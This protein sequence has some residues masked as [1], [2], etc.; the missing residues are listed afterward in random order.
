MMKKSSF[1]TLKVLKF[2]DYSW[3][4]NTQISFQK[5]ENKTNPLLDEKKNIEK[6]YPIKTVFMIY[7]NFKFTASRFLKIPQ[8]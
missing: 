7:E 2:L 5:N 3:C 6:L 4:I 1:F 8:E